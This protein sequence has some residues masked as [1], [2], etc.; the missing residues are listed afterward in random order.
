MRVIR[1]LHQGGRKLLLRASSRILID[2][3][4][5]D[6]FSQFEMHT[7]QSRVDRQSLLV[8]RDR[9]RSEEPREPATV[10]KRTKTGVR[11]AASVRWV[12]KRRDPI[13]FETEQT[14]IGDSYLLSENELQNSADYF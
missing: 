9:A 3:V 2:L 11:R 14:F 13:N 7:G 6:G 5:Q 8:L 10:E 12:P 1:V 4:T